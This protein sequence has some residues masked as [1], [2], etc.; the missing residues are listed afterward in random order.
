MKISPQGILSVY[1][2]LVTDES[3]QLYKKFSLLFQ[4]L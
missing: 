4:A 3:K 2:F 1:D